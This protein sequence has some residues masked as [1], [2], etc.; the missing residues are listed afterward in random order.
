[1]IEMDDER[2][3]Q[4]VREY[5]NA[6]P[7]G[8]QFTHLERGSKEFYEEVERFRYET[9]PFMRRVMEFDGFKGKKLLEIGC[10][11][12]TDLL[13]F[14]RG[15]ALVTGV[16]LTP[17]SVELVK[18]RFKLNNL[19]VETMVADAEKLPFED[20]SFDVLY[21]FG[22]LHHTP[23]TPKAVDEV[24]RVL[25]PGGRIIIM[26]YHKQS[27]HVTLGTMYAALAGFSSKGKDEK[28]NWVR[29]YDGDGNPL[30]KAYSR[31]EVELMF[32]KFKNLR[33]TTVDPY[34][35]KL[36]K[37]ANVL[38]QALFSWWWGFWLV[39]KGTK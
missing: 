3:K 23:N 35:R 9:Q 38:N 1:M 13:Q 33:L 39:I 31:S 18:R 24:Y 20:N 32:R 25:K 36:P 4:E 30:G 37:I 11:L 5:W 7:C 17:A 12:G 15:G 21:S 27:M 22:V 16:D 14:A 28:E 26:L 19:A 6:N 29:I 10:G 34:R 8:T 2:L